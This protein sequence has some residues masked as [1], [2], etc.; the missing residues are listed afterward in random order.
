MKISTIEA[1]RKLKIH[2]GILFLFV[3]ELA[4]TVQ[5][6]D[7]WPEIDDGWVATIE[8]SKGISFPRPSGQ[9]SVPA[10]KPVEQKPAALSEPARKIVDKLRRHKHWG[11]ASLPI[12][13]LLKITHLSSKE[14]EEAID[15]LKG[16]HI[17]DHAGGSRG[18]VSLDPAK[19]EEIESIE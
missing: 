1:A 10:L 7:L 16:K 15:E 13:A 12:E 18:V 8:R 11:H 6:E 4:P 9:V 19:K 17:L 5:F 2:P 14:V 3:S